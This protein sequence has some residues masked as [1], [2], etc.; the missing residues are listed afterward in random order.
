MPLE[1][2]TGGILVLLGYIWLA[3]SDD[4]TLYDQQHQLLLEAGVAEEHLYKDIDGQ[5]RQA[6]PGLESCMAALQAGDTLAVCQL[7]QLVDGRL[8]LLQLLEQ[9]QQRQIGLQVLSGQGAVL[10]TTQNSLTVSI[11]ILAALSELE[12]QLASEATKAGIAAARQRGKALGAKPKITPTLLRQIITDLSNTDDSL[13]AIAKKH[14]INRVTIYNYL[15]GDGS[16]KPRGRKLL[17]V[18]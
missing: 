2:S 16:L 6:R 9:L 4:D 3:S 17:D 18:E 13:T 7:A 8:Q 12:D 14:G 5:R 15:N 1:W 10:S 11:P